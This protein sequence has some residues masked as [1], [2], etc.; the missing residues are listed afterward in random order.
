M[1]KVSLN[2]L[3]RE[4]GMTPRQAYDAVKRILDEEPVSLDFD[5]EEAACEFTRRAESFGAVVEEVAD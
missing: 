5:S 4:V 3:L 2:Y 1:K